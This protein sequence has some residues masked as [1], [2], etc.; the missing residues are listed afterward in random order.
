MFA[1]PRGRV[2]E[3]PKKVPCEAG[4][5]ASLWVVHQG[6]HLGCLLIFADDFTS[7]LM[8]RDCLMIISFM[9][10]MP[11]R[12][13]G[14]TGCRGSCLVLGSSPSGTSSM[15]VGLRICAPRSASRLI[16]FVSASI[17]S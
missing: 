17:A 16:A 5:G 9:S 12:G 6:R 2:R 4:R 1:R 15:M 8:S 13:R 14:V 3:N 11:G 7:L 10:Q